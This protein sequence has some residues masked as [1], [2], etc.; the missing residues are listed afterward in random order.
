MWVTSLVH[1]RWDIMCKRGR[2]GIH[3]ATATTSRPHA[4]VA[5]EPHRAA[6]LGTLPF[7]RALEPTATSQRQA[8]RFSSPL[9]LANAQ[10]KRGRGPI[11]H[12][13]GSTAS[14]P[15]PASAGG[16]ADNVALE[17]IGWA[18]G[19]AW[20]VTALMTTQA[21]ARAALQVGAAAAPSKRA[22]WPNGGTCSARS[23]WEGLS[24]RGNVGTHSPH[25][26]SCVKHLVRLCPARCV[27]ILPYSKVGQEGGARMRCLEG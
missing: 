16:Q 19:P 14:A 27:C 26:R 12:G 17:G 25:T 23:G 24:A 21:V 7:S 4:G 9:G 6:S 10:R 22:E 20:L 2:E 15:A 18:P 11:I 5:S 1:R 13:S 8:S 3:S